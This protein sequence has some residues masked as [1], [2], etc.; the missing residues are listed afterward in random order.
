MFD[1]FLVLLFF[2]GES[3][4]TEF[5]LLEQK[6]SVQSE[7]VVELEETGWEVGIFLSRYVSGILKNVVGEDPVFHFNLVNIK[8]FSSFPAHRLI[9]VKVWYTAHPRL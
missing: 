6:V 9:P 2:L 3:Y 4:L 7:F 5:I 8:R 1:D